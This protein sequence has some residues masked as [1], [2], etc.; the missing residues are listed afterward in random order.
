MDVQQENDKFHADWNID[1]V[2]KLICRKKP[3]G[4]RRVKEL[5]FLPKYPVLSL[6]RFARY[7]E[8]TVKGITHPEI[9]YRDRLPKI[10]ELP[11]SV[12][13]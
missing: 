7:H 10:E 4:F 13:Y 5:L 9:V 11:T 8:A 3:S 1:F 6:Y 2:E 12:V